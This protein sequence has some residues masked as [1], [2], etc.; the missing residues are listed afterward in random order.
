MKKIPKVAREI[1]EYIK[2]YDRTP[3]DL[4]TRLNVSTVTVQKYL[5]ELCADGYIEKVGKRPHVHYQFIRQLPPPVIKSTSID[6]HFMFLDSIGNIH[7]G[8]EAFRIW[9]EHNLKKYPLEEKVRYYEQCIRD[10]KAQKQNGVYTLDEK[11][12][13]FKKKTSEDVFIEGLVCTAP[14]ALPDFGKTKEAI[15]LGIAKDGGRNSKMYMK[16]LIDGFV[17]P[18]LTYLRY[19][20]PR[21]VAFIPPTAERKVQ[22]MDE[23]KK[24]F[25]EI[26]KLP[27]IN[28][29][30]KYGNVVLQQ[31]HLSNIR[32][33]VQNAD[34]T[35]FPDETDREYSSVLLIDDMIG[36]GASLNQVAKKL[37]NQKSAKRVYGIGIVGNQKGF[38][39]V[40]K[41]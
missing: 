18:L 32:D 27:I 20:K 8:T 17:P 6:N 25:C 5:K 19:L 34:K 31:K 10:M 39:T 3:K 30:K 23:I 9:S 15:L 7:T 11:W 1:V 33:R 26:S 14:Y 36:S 24:Q 4:C 37:I 29:R 41:V 40:K 2:Q 21:A 12:K 16:Q 38:T 13:E 35:F 28:I 22:L